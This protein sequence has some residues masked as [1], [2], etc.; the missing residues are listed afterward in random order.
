MELHISNYNTLVLGSLN[1][2]Y[3]FYIENDPI[4]DFSYIPKKIIRTAGGHGGNCAVSVARL[5]GR[6]GLLSCVGNDE[7]GT[8]LIN[9]LLSENVCTDYVI[10]KDGSSGNVFIPI[11]KN[12]YKYMI[13]DRGANDQI[14]K[15]DIDIEDISA[16]Y[17]SVIVFD[18]EREISLEILKRFN[19]L[20]KLSS[21]VLCPSSKLC[22]ADFEEVGYPSFII[23][24]SE[25]AKIIPIEKLSKH[26]NIIITMG[27]D[28]LRAIFQG[29]DAIRINGILTNVYDTVGAGDCFAGLLNFFLLHD[30]D[31]YMALTLA[32]KG[33]AISTTSAGARE[34]LPNLMSIM[35]TDISDNSPL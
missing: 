35:E 16:N 12:N 24:N 7:N 29:G 31:I 3:T 1:I 28:G 25:E 9:D 27:A 21:V 15:E 30:V 22:A 14:S 13:M 32:N 20:N 26:T 18:L 4:D 23:V 10:R 33:A 17:S 8:F 2:D 19:R 34:G 6:V 5:G 11:F